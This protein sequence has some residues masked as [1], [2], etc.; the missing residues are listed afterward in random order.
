MRYV[1][2]TGLPFQY[3]FQLSSEVNV[4]LCIRSM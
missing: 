3:R 1:P 4:R 2:E